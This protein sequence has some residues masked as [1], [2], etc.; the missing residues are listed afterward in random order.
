MLAGV[1]VGIGPG[2]I[3][4]PLALG[5]AALFGV[6]GFVSLVGA[7]RERRKAPRQRGR[8]GPGDRF[9][10][11]LGLSAACLAWPFVILRHPELA[12]R[13]DETAAFWGALIGVGGLAAIY[14]VGKR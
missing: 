3:M 5:L 6:L 2:L 14:F 9:L 4:L 1:D 8:S 7:V 11:A 10:V 12:Q 13:A